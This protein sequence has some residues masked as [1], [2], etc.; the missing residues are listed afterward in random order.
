MT[1]DPFPL[2]AFGD[3]AGS[4]AQEQVD[5]LV[6][7]GLHGLDVR[8]VDGVNVL[9][10]TDEALMATREACEAHGR[11]VQAV[12]S[13]INKVAF[14][15][16]TLNDETQKLAGAIKAAKILGTRRIRIFT[17][18]TPPNQGPAAWAE[19]KPVMETMVSMAAD[20]DVVLIH[21]NDGHYYGAFPAHAK[22]LFEAIGGPHFRAAFDFANTVLIGFRPMRDWFPWLLP[23]LDTLHIKDAVESEHQVV[24]AGEGDGQLV[25]TL[26]FLV[27]QN[28]HGPL[29]LEPHLK[30]AGPLGGYS[31]PELFAYAAERMKAVVAE[32][33]GSVELA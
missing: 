32:A 3:E 26:R 20:A 23:H 11:H 22:R 4:S 17:P 14:S 33:G 30:A 6:K 31:G 16:S 29:T 19:L 12:G 27:S 15:H 25:E 10:M 28:W 18:E 13:P 21:E 2:S 1:T 5:A 7:S 24:A 9:A 8:S